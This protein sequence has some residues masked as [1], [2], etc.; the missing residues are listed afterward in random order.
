MQR[1]QF[2]KIVADSVQISLSDKG[3]A[4]ASVPPEQVDSLVDAIA[5]GVF[6]GLMATLDEQAPDYIAPGAATTAGAPDAVEWPLPPADATTWA[7]NPTPPGATTARR[8]E[9][10]ASVPPASH[11]DEVLLWRGR[12]YMTIGRIYELTT[13]RLRLIH[14]VVSNEIDEIELVRVRDTRVTQNVGER[15][16]DIGDVTIFSGDATSPEKVLYNIKDPVTVRELIR[17]AVYEERERRRMLY[18]EDLA[19]FRRELSLGA[20]PDLTRPSV[21][22]KPAEACRSIGSYPDV[23]KPNPAA[24]LPPG[25]C[26]AAQCPTLSM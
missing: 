25:K 13:Q 18:R 6:A 1:D 8:A 24:R 15:M 3:A 11:T 9:L 5:D 19:G 21:S 4:L 16:F 23:S 10:L 2:R 20:G 12:P 22:G 17:K 26:R 14:G 7:A